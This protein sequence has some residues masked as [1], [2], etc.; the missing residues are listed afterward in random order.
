MIF[1]LFTSTTTN[2]KVDILCEDNLFI[3]V[4]ST[5]M[6][7]I[8]P[9]RCPVDGKSIDSNKIFTDTAF[10]KQIADVNIVCCYSSNGCEWEGNIQSLKEHRENC[11][12]TDI[13]CPNGCGKRVSKN[14]LINHSCEARKCK[15]CLMELDAEYEETHECPLESRPGPEGQPSKTMPSEEETTP[16]NNQGDGDSLKICKFSKLGCK[17]KGNR[18]ELDLHMD[19]ASERHLDI[20][21]KSIQDIKTEYIKKEN[22]VI[23]KH[24]N[25]IKML[26]D[27]IAKQNVIIKDLHESQQTLETSY[28]SIKNNVNEITSQSQIFIDEI[29]RLKVQTNLLQDE[30]SEI[31]E[32]NFTGSML[33]KV[34]DVSEHIK[35][36]VNKT[37]LSIYSRPFYTSRYGYK[38]RA[39][40]FLNGLGTHTGEFVSIYF[41]ILP[42][43]HDDILK[44]PFSHKITF[45]LLEQSDDIDKANNVSYTLIPSPTEDNYKKPT[46][47]MSE[48][49]GYNK[50]ISIEQLKHGRYIKNNCVFIK[51]RVHCKGACKK[52]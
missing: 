42:T 36:A 51:M 26:Q 17:F 9:S 18:F 31:K 37:E 5:C 13:I 16:T 27:Y 14:E 1:C 50:F 6:P 34:K 41:H 39:Q 7:R 33:W 52:D 8:T 4:S 47:K 2:Q 28:R 11:K 49:R 30:L 29:T 21:C 20:V 3:Y 23:T 46:E 32:M 10:E 38:L 48:G 44:W 43:E 24:D 15:Q 22:R 25:K 19:I 45:A 35:N 40:L 12:Y